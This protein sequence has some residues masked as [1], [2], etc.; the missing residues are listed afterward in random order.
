MPKPSARRNLAVIPQSEP[1]PASPE[2]SAEPADNEANPTSRLTLPLSADG[3][4]D[5]GRLREKTKQSLRRALSD[6]GLSVALGTSADGVA[7]TDDAA[8]GMVVSAIYDGVSA[9][10][11]YLAHRAGY[12]IERCAVLAFTADEK[13]SLEPATARVVNKYLPDLGGQYRD[14][15]V[16]ALAL[17][18]VIAGKII[19]LRSQPAQPA[20]AA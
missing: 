4:V 5:I 17:T 19:M 7:A 10:S 13:R 2:P 8:I 15:L 11:V 16:L 12:P 9:L 20:E 18:N 6:P 1:D 14:E 3:R